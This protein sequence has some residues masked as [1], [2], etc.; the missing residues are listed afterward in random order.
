MDK[1]N[2]AAFKEMLRVMKYLIQ[3][4]DMALR[5]APKFDKSTKMTKWKLRIFSDS[6]WASN[7]DDRK[8][9]TGFVILLCETPI[10]WKSQSQRT[11][12][13]SSTEAEYYATAEAAKEIKFVVQVLESLNLEVDKPII[14]HID[15]VGAI[16]VAENASATKHT[17]HIDARYHFVREYI[18]D[19]QIKIIFV[20]SKANMADMFTKNV[21]SEIY[22][23]HIDNFLI[24]REVIKLTSA[25]LDSIQ[26]FDSGGVSEIKTSSPVPVHESQNRKE[27]QYNKK[28]PPYN[29]YIDEYLLGTY[30]PKYKKVNRMNPLTRNQTGSNNE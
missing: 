27:P 2:P 28:E 7:K 3:T 25:N 10:L 29:K 24:H 12:S 30:I 20:M 22:E 19:G 15:N 11:V 14:V 18:I 8:S 4:K 26:F 1:A 6:D 17:R 5:I 23:E 21:T 9:I 13:L 16:F